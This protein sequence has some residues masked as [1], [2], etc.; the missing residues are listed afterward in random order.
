[1]FILQAA[2]S[3]NSIRFRTLN[4]GGNA[5]QIEIDPRNRTSPFTILEPRN[6]EIRDIYVVRERRATDFKAPKLCGQARVEGTFLRLL[7]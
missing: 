5:V 4:C 2:I 6:Q 7:S 3:L 1:M